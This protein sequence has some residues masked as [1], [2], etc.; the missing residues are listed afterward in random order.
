[1]ANPKYLNALHT[2]VDIDGAS[3]PWD[4]DNDRPLDWQCYAG[5]LWEAAK[6]KYNI[7]KPDEYV[8]PPT[9]PE[10]IRQGDFSADAS[11]VDL[12]TR[13]QGATIA[14]I[15]A[16]L[17]ANVTTVAAARAVFKAIVKY[18]VARALI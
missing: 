2:M 3:V 11:V 6:A 5:R 4:A 14:E 15:D 7:T 12:R 13:L 18:L 16:W 9:P 8:A 17:D 10:V 1:M